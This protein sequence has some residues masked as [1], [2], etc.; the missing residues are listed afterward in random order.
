VERTVIL[1]VKS[2]ALGVVGGVLLAAVVGGT[3]LVIEMA[4]LKVRLNGAEQEKLGTQIQTEAR[5]A[6]VEAAET[7]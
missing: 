5:I 7:P 6:Y 3:P 4:G 2:A 1:D